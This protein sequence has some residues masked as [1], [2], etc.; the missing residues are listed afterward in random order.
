MLE[1]I[2]VRGWDEGRR[3]EEILVKTV[4][5]LENCE[6]DMIRG[7]ALTVRNPDTRGSHGGAVCMPQGSQDNKPQETMIAPWSLLRYAR[8]RTTRT[9]A[10]PVKNTRR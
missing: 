8:A 5:L 10:P 6:H 4:G 7:N 3:T 1:A 9:F 2:R